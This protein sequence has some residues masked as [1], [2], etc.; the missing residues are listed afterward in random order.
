MADLAKS[1][2]VKVKEFFEGDRHGRRVGKVVDAQVTLSSMGSTSNKIP[3]TAFD[4][5][6]VRE[7]QTCGKDGT[8]IGAVQF[9]PS[10]DGTLIYAVNLEQATDATRGDPVDVSGTYRMVIRGH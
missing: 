9:I 8:P 5:A 10:Y 7:V 2:V 6:Y 1:G 3:A 4:M